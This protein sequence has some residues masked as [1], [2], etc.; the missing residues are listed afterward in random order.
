MEQETLHQLAGDDCVQPLF[1]VTWLWCR[2]VMLQNI[3][4]SPWLSVFLLHCVLTLEYLKDCIWQCSLSSD[5]SITYIMR[6]SWLMKL[7]HLE[8]LLASKDRLT[9][10]FRALHLYQSDYH[11]I[12]VEEEWVLLGWICCKLN[13][14]VKFLSGCHSE[15][16]KH[17]TSD[18]WQG[19]C[20]ALDYFKDSQVWTMGLSLAGLK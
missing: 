15:I 8:K 13:Y 19:I 4:Y 14:H 2:Q 3:R 16:P 20:M 18:R 17:K 6:A 7:V 12:M 1:F 11:S 5:S 10:V 9:F